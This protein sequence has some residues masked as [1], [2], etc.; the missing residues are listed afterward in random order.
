MHAR[1]GPMAGQRRAQH[2]RGGVDA[3]AGAGRGAAAGCPGGARRA[4]RGGGALPRHRQP[5]MAGRPRRTRG[6]GRPRQGTRHRPRRG[7]SPAQRRP[8]RRSTARHRV[9]GGR[10]HRTPGAGSCHRARLRCR[11][12]PGV[13][14]PRARTSGAGRPGRG[15]GRRARTPD[16]R[17]ARRQRGLRLLPQRPRDRAPA[18][19][20]DAA[21]RV[22]GVA[23]SR[24]R[25]QHGAGRHPPGTGHRPDVPLLPADRAGPLR[26]GAGRVLPRLPRG[27][28]AGTRLEC[29]GRRRG[30]RGLHDRR[31]HL[32]RQRH[33]ARHRP[34][35]G[36]C[37][38]TRPHPLPALHGLRPRRLPC[39]H[40]RARPAR[41]GRP[42]GQPR[43]R[44]TPVRLRRRH[45]EGP[46]HADQRFPPP[47]AGGRVSR[48][49]GSRTGVDGARGG[50]GPVRAV[51]RTGPVRSAG[52]RGAAVMM[53][54][55]H[56]IR[57][58]SAPLPCAGRTR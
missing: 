37:P 4:L 53:S 17:A 13:V 8:G 48:A 12:G 30:V 10:H 38:G 6:H 25:G 24:L 28:P 21:P 2:G 23:G 55:P 18:G 40:H 26:R 50:R 11:G 1:G 14:G 47:G 22:P 34:R 33:R 3:G 7:T 56:V 49:A 29:P 9:H 32:R 44:D 27:H 41:P 31:D 58:A 16:A 46:R 20:G 43:R 57:A 15:P 42:V 52:G 35:P 5:G 45:R 19:P 54:R 39:G 36:P 51:T